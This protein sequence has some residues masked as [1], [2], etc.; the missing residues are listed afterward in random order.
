MDIRRGIF[1]AAAALC[2]IGSFLMPNAVAEVTDARRLDSLVIVEAQSINIDADLKLSLPER[3]ALAASPYMETL[4]LTTGQMLTVETAGAG[5][6]REIEKFFSGGPFE[7]TNEGCKVE[8]SAVL[9][10]ADS[11]DPSANMI[12]WEFKLFD[13]N[14]NEVNV[15]IDDET[16]MILKLIYRQGGEPVDR[17]GAAGESAVGSIYDEM[18]NAALY[19]SEMMAEYYGLR[20]RLG[21]YELGVNIAYYRA[22]M[23]GGGITAPMYGVIRANG[24]TM[25]ERP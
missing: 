12:V 21:D 16:G 17:E 14:E 20:V 7:F 19:L 2:L 5:A 15:T 18:H 3:I 25:N 8:Y 10:M 23:T 13:R 6:I 1:P 22:D 24:F 11:E 4:A 9:L